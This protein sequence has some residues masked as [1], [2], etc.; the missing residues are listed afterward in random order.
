LSAHSLFVSLSLSLYRHVTSCLSIVMSCHLVVLWLFN[1]GGGRGGAR[2]DNHKTS[3][4]QAQDNN[5][6][7]SDKT[8]GFLLH[9]TDVHFFCFG[10]K[11][12]LFFW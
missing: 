5:K 2:Q 7:R 10:M 6:A 1:F 4:Q 8:V 11:P 3:T 9:M 12:L